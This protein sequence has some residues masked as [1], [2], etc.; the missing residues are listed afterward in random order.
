MIKKIWLSLLIFLWATATITS[1]EEIEI[2]PPET[3]EECKIQLRLWN[4]ANS[5]GFDR[6]GRFY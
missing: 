4:C 3:F 6:R 2:S 5:F 1:A